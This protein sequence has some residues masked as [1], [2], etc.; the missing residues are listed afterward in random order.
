MRLSRFQLGIIIFVNHQQTF[1]AV[2]FL[3]TFAKFIHKLCQYIFIYFLK[4]PQLMITQF[5]NDPWTRLFRIPWTLMNWDEKKFIKRRNFAIESNFIVRSLDSNKESKINKFF[6]MRKTKNAKKKFAQLNWIRIF[7]CAATAVT[8]ELQSSS[9]YIC[10]IC[11]P[12]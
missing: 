1:P 6:W 3:L 11:L 9:T 5:M 8:I 2:A 7:V 4:W 10:V 12:R